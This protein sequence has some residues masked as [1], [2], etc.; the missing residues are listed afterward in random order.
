[1]KELLLIRH[2]KS[3]RDDPSLSD[4]D[5]SLDARGK[6][7]AQFM[8]SLLRFQGREPDR[9]VSSPAR[10]AHKTA[11]LIAREVRYDKDAIVMADGLYLGGAKAIVTLVQALDDRDK[12][13]YLVG[14]NPDLSEAASRLTGEDLGEMPTCGVISMEFPVDRWAYVMEGAGRLKFFEYPKRHLMT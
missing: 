10:R 3:R 9:I 7:D 13:V 12:R 2:A 1:L 5:R 4:R 14:H 8:G 6:R 11:R